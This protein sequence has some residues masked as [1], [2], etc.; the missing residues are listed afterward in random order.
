MCRAV[1]ARAAQRGGGP[2]QSCVTFA[3]DLLISSRHR[4]RHTL[5]D[6]RSPDLPHMRTDRRTDT[7]LHP[8][9]KT[10]TLTPSEDN[11]RSGC[12]GRRPFR[13]YRRRRCGLLPSGVLTCRAPRRCLPAAAATSGPFVF[14]FYARRSPGAGGNTIYVDFP[15]FLPHTLYSGR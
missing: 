5:T 6:R 7:V 1:S 3:R 13:V 15:P 9:T 14:S 11:H 10:G 2:L 8:G 4:G 12:P